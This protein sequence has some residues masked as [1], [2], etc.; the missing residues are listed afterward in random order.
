MRSAMKVGG[1][2]K[3][4]CLECKAKGHW[5][6]AQPIRSPDF[7]DSINSILPQHICTCISEENV[8]TV[9][10]QREND[11]MEEVEKKNC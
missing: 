3:G 4:L 11:V 9:E 7:K 1:E 2:V 5:S 8:T 6:L 10:E